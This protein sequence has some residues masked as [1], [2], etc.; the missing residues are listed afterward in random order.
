MRGCIASDPE[1]KGKTDGDLACRTA[2]ELGLLSV[3]C[4]YCIVACNRELVTCAL[5]HALS[6][7]LLSLYLSLIGWVWQGHRQGHG[8]I[9]ELYLVAF[10]SLFLSFDGNSDGDGLTGFCPL[11]FCIEYPV[12]FLI[13]VMDYLF[14]RVACSDERGL[15]ILLLPCSGAP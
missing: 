15:T 14:M 7:I 2:R 3:A 12:V 1:L 13:I 6:G 8:H 11:G 5:L 10:V 9:G 4:F